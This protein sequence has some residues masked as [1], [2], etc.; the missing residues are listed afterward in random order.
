MSDDR[1]ASLGLRPRARIVSRV[2]VGSDP[3]LMF[4]GVAPA[5]LRAL[6]RA[7]LRLGDIDVIEIS[8]A[9][10][11]VVLAWA[12][13]LEPEMD[14]V[15]P[16]GGA[17]ALG[18]PVGASGA[19]L[20]TTLLHELERRGGRYGLEVVCIGGGMATAMVIERL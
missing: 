11:P 15:N 7:G 1:A 18:H 8:E 3:V 9:F 16:N 13:E 19:R 12:A 6:E 5:T 17:I 20:A 14:R 4:T 2:V 10:A